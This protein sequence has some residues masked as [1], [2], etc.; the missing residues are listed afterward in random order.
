MNRNRTGAGALR[1]LL[2]AVCIALCA[3]PANADIF[4]KLKK[5]AKES[6][7]KTK[8]DMQQTVEQETGVGGKSN[9][10]SLSA[11]S[12]KSTS[13]A[14]A[15]AP[16]ASSKPAKN[17]TATKPAS[18]PVAT[19]VASKPAALD[20]LG[21]A[22]VAK[23]T[24]SCPTTSSLTKTYDCGCLAE[25]YGNTLMDMR[26]KARANWENNRKA[27]EEARLARA[28]QMAAQNN[29]PSVAQR[30]Q[31]R[32]DQTVA[33]LDKAPASDQVLVHVL[34]ESGTGKRC[35][36]REAIVKTNTER[37]L[38]TPGKQL[39]S[40]APMDATY[41]SC[42]ANEMASNI[43]DKGMHFG[44]ARNHASLSCDPSLSSVLKSGKK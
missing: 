7:Q 43:V 27:Y 28:K 33:S 41:C 9:A 32:Y 24:A 40:G 5:Q 36:S 4:D 15:S 13:A 11:D 12:A 17:P 39:P 30:A 23:F 26:A 18:K 14:P 35:Y 38:D 3:T 2:A 37:C 8:Q 31:A 20:A 1:A 34:G 44:P 6:A 29:D 42:L 16:V 25:E 21:K 19:P 10:Q 22:E